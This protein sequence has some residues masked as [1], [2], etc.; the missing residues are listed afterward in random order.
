M[1][2]FGKKK[3]ADAFEALVA[4]CER[5]VYFTC[6]R[7]IGNRQDAEDCAQETMLRAFRAFSSFRN[8]SKV[9]TWLYTI[10]ARVCMDFFRKKKGDLS[11]DA[12]QAEGW[13]Q[14]DD[15]PSAYLQLETK[16]RRALLEQALTELPDGYRAA[17]VLCD[18]QGLSYEETAEALEVPIGTIRSRLS[19]ARSMLQKILS[20]NAELFSDN[21]RP[22]DERREHNGL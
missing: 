1:S 15:A 2:L 18:L 9:S 7:M 19:R 5:Q 10:A 16:E 22:M 20:K 21:L 4:P 12:L 8:E 13:E 14:A 3:Q 6:L 11:L 17:V